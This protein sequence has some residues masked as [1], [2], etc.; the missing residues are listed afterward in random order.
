M[1]VIHHVFS[2]WNRPSV[3][4]SHIRALYLKWV[5][6]CGYAKLKVINV[7]LMGG[8]VLLV[9]QEIGWGGFVVKRRCAKK[10]ESL[11][12]VA[13]EQNGIIGGTTLSGSVSQPSPA[14][15]AFW[16]PFFYSLPSPHCTLHSRTGWT[17]GKGGEEV[18]L[19]G[20]CS[21]ISLFH[22]FFWT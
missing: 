10:K 16:R 14:R 1:R 15:Q 3:V 20:L 6:L 22:Y 8:C 11:R 9:L 5:G 13:V 4:A 21:F 7:R 18:S 2:L 17:G 12:C 19:W